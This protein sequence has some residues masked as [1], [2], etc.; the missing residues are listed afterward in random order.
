MTAHK[1]HVNQI[2]LGEWPVQKVGSCAYLG[3]HPENSG[4]TGMYKNASI[5]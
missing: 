3:G 4:A 1:Q 5:I 2:H